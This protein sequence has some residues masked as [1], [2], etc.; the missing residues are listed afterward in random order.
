[1]ETISKPTVAKMLDVSMRMVEKHEAR[2]V[3]PLPVYFRGRGKTR[4]EYDPIA[5]CKWAIR[6]EKAQ[7]IKDNDGSPLNLEH[8]NARL[9]HHRANKTCLE[10]QKL[11]G[12]LIEA[13]DVTEEWEKIAISLK[14]KLLAAPNKYAHRVIGLKSIKDANAVFTDVARELLTEL[15]ND[16][17]IED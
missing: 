1:M 2:E 16:D 17:A 11:A 5:I 15:S 4:N 14:A 12:T 10:E 9:A 8:E 13:S 3:D 7:Y 6:Q